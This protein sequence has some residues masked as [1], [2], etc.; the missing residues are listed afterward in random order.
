[1]LCCS[2]TL[3]FSISHPKIFFFSTSSKDF[4]STIQQIQTFDQSIKILIALHRL[5]K[6]TT[7]WCKQY[8]E[9]DKSITKDLNLISKFQ[10]LCVQSLLVR[11]DHEFTNESNQV[12]PHSK[13]DYQRVSLVVQQ[14]QS[15]CECFLENRQ[16]KSEEKDALRAR[17]FLFPLRNSWFCL[18]R[19]CGLTVVVIH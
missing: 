17:L 18:A 2:W 6:P 16:L 15:T 19:P 11:A 5:M 4:D 12:E 10:H 7:A 8:I 14:L 1:M 9:I 13:Y 3:G